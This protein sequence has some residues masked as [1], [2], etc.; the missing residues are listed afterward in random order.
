L[1]PSG[2]LAGAGIAL[3]GAQVISFL[4]DAVSAAAEFQ[5]SVSATGVIFGE[6]AIPAMEAWADTAH[7][8]FGASKQDALAAANQFAVF[9]KSAGLMGE[10]LQGFST[11][12]VQLGG[13]LASMFGGTTQEAITAVGAALRGESEPIRRYGV[14]LDDATLRQ[15]A[16][17]MGLISTT[18]NALTPQQRVL[19]AQTEIL[20]QTTDAQ[21]DFERTSA[22]MANQQRKLQAQLENVSIE[23]GEKLLPVMVKLV[24]FLNDNLIPALMT[25]TDHLGRVGDVITMWDVSQPANDL[26]DKLAPGLREVTEAANEAGVSNEEFGRRL[27]AVADRFD[28]D[29]QTIIRRTHEL[30]EA[31]DSYAV[32]WDKAVKEVSGDNAEMRADAFNTYQAVASAAVEG[33]TATTA[34]V[35]EGFAEQARIRQAHFQSEA[36]AMRA[37]GYENTVQLAMGLLDAQNEPKV[38]MEAL[39]RIQEE[40]MTRTEEIAYLKGQAATLNTANGLRS[41]NVAVNLAA[42]AVAAEINE[43]LEELG[44]EAY[45]WGGDVGRSLAAGLSDQYYPVKTAAGLVASAI[46]GTVGIQSEPEDPTSPLRGITDWG[47]NIVRTMAEGVLGDLRTASRASDA[48]AAALVP[49]LAAVM[50]PGFGTSPFGL[51]SL[52]GPVTAGSAGEITN[53][54]LTIEGKEPVVSSAAEIVEAAARLRKTWG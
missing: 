12:M 6:E 4:G 26:V 51:S 16:F 17:E 7:S 29:G 54:N 47:G 32:A 35:E 28:V 14:L 23:I 33:M 20:A 40:S 48:L 52:P 15:R 50:A 45:D 31:G 9:G 8:A 43:R 25:V 5:D 18:Q 2:L 10:E 19:A 36:L 34:A 27:S 42:Q 1:T 39:A 30:M 37:A 46:R 11:E 13:D 22:G 21:G 53:I 24:T 49:R 3:G 44:A 38:A 41:E